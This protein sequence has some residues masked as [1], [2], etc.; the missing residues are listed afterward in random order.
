MKEPKKKVSQALENF[1]KGIPEKSKKGSGFLKSQIPNLISTW[2]KKWRVFS[3]LMRIFVSLIIQ[4]IFRGI[5]SKKNIWGEIFKIRKKSRR[6]WSLTEANVI[7]KFFS[8]GIYQ[9]WHVQTADQ[10]YYWIFRILSDDLF[11][12]S[13]SRD[14]SNWATFF[15][16]ELF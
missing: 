12:K 16:Q 7:F 14:I 8:L 15:S 4:K 1:S 3:S 13:N 9:C 6:F 2:K 10:N 5:F 11:P